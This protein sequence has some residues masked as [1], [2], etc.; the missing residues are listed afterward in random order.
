[1]KI[2][3]TSAYSMPL[4]GGP[5]WDQKNP[6][7]SVY[8]TIEVLMLQYETDPA[9][10][11]PLLPPSYKP[12]KSPSVTIMFIDSNGVD[13]MAGGGYRFASVAVAARFDGEAGHMEGDYVLIMPENDTRPIIMGREFLGMPK[14]FADI[15]SIRTLDNGHLRCEAS[16]WGHP[17]F[18]LD[19]APPFKKQNPLVVRAAAAQVNKTPAFGY[20]YIASL[21][22][23]PDADYPTVMWSETEIER[24]WFGAT[25]EFHIG[26][27]REQDIGLLAPAFE[28]LR[29][30]P[31]RK[32]LR[33][34]HLFGSMALLT[35]KNGRIR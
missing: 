9:A 23:P 28:V 6:P 20:K 29:S 8:S 10:I 21:N 22:G 3:P 12:G 1:M 16:L 19:I 26:N 2:D 27:A 32:V 17:L 14:F 24:L 34:A 25:G 15:S 13:F 11:P 30:L 5:L 4:I 7:K 33:A 35:A 18:G 31:A